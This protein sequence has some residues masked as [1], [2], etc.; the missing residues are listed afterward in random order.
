MLSTDE[1]IELAGIGQLRAKTTPPPAEVPAGYTALRPLPEPALRV[2]MP[3]SKKWIII[4]SAAGAGVILL[5][6]LVLLLR[7]R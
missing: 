2:P 6:T 3:S 5:T 1:E 7:R 4:A